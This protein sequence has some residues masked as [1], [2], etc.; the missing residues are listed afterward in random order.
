VGRLIELHMFM[1]REGYL[2]ERFR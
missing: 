2:E 1:T